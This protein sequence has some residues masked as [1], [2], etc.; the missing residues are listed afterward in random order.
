[1]S[2]IT[3][4][5]GLASG[6]DTES[7]VQ[8]LMKA[9][10]MPLD[11]VKQNQQK[12]L[13]QSEMYRQ[14]N[15]ELFTFR[16]K[17]LF[18]M[19]LS[20]SYNTFDVTSSISNSLSGVSTGDAVPGTYDIAVKQI[21]QSATFTANKVDLDASKTLG[22]AAQGDRKLT[23]DTT[24]SLKVFNDPDK[25]TS[26]STV[27]ITLKTTD[28]IY[29]V[30]S[31]FNNATD[32]FGKNIGLQANYDVTLQQFTLR[33]KATGETTKIEFTSN[34]D[35]LSKTLGIGTKASI[36][37]DNA[38]TSVNITSGTND[39]L[40]F[41]LGNGQT[42]SISLLPG[43]YT[44]TQLVDQINQAISDNSILATQVYAL[45]D[46]S[47]GKITFTSQTTGSTSYLSVSGIGLSAIGYTSAKTASG[48][49]SLSATG[50]NARV[51]FNGNEVSLASN[52]SNLYGVNYTFKS[53]T[54]DSDGKVISSK[55]TISRNIDNEVENIKK[56]IEKYNELLEKLNKVVDEP[57]YRSYQPLTDEQKESLS[58]EQVKKWE[59]KAKSGILRRDSILSTLS[60]KM[61]AIMSSTVDNG[62]EY[63]SLS[64]IGIKSNSYTDQGKL[65]IDEDKLRKA[66]QEDPEA[67][68]NLF[69]QTK[70]GEGTQGFVTRLYDDFSNTIKD[71]TEKAGAAGSSQFDQSTIGKLLD[72]AQDRI[73]RFEDILQRKENNYYRQ[74]TAMEKAMSQYNSQGAWL[75]Q[76]F[77]GGMY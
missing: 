30:V 54:V 73:D 69:T 59:E 37:G 8:K 60:F 67:V 24:V 35:V 39:Q 44:A 57:V 55:V 65:Y 31:K 20:K 28:T 64:A 45:L 16:T 36:T 75:M 56:F 2:S 58:E 19:K 68:K 38:V 23:A 72:N 9:E 17:T 49:A 71:L 15:T 12:M 50:Q 21:A 52:T 41:D 10:R 18:D 3:R 76:Q 7:L 48:V 46:S 66:L 25:P 47:T 43:T 63:N 77:G 13:W 26:Y 70:E 11:R 62:S 33:T 74:F 5:T 14:W 29:D 22:D 42:A 61:R 40:Q 32:S 4:L 27:N 6:M 1:M 34:A 51:V 53:P